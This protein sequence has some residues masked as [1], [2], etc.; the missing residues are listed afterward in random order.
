MTDDHE[1][2]AEALEQRISSLSAAILRINESLDLA[3]VLREVVECACSLTATTRGVIATTDEAGAVLEYVSAGFTDEEHYRMAAW[4]DGP[5]LF[6]HMRDLPAPL[7][8]TNLAEWVCEL[9][10]ATDILPSEALVGMPLRHRGRHVGNFFVGMKDNGAE[11]TS[12]DEEILALFASQAATAIANAR[13]HQSEQRAR[14]DLEALIDTSPVGVVVF[15]VGTGKAPTINREAQRIVESLRTP[16][17]PVE[18]LLEEATCRLADGREIPFDQFPLAGVLS[19]AATTRAEEIVLS[20]PGGRRVSALINATPIRSKEGAVE[21]MVVTMQDLAPIEELERQRAAFLDMVSHELRAPLAAITGSAVTL[22]STAAT[23]DRSEMRAFFRIIT[24]QAEHMRSLVSDLLD[25]GRI[26]SGAL[27]VLP[28][29]SDVATLVD[30]ARNTFVSGGARHAVAIDLAPHLPRVMAD[31]R[32]IVQV[33]INLLANAARQAPDTAP[34]RIRAVRDATHVA[35]SVRDEGRG[36][37]PERLTQLFRKHVHADGGNGGSGISGGLGLAICKGLVEAHGGRIRAE[38]DG[39]GTG[40]CFTFTVPVAAEA[41]MAAA[42]GEGQR[43]SADQE[44]AARV[45]VVDDDPQA[46]RFVRE[47]LTEAGFTVLVTG[48]H[49]ELS[50]LVE[51]EH[52]DLILLDLVLAD[53]DGIELMQHSPELAGLPVIFISA[54]GRDATIARALDGGAADYIVKPFSPTELVARIRAALRG[55]AEPEPFVL[56]DLAIQYA[57]RRVL[58]AGKPVDLTATEFELLRA[59]SLAA[60]RV[61]TYDVLLHRVWRGAGDAALVRAFV[62]QLRRKLGDNP[63]EPVWIFNQRGVGYRMPRPEVCTGPPRHAAR[64]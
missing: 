17:R 14:A 28:E 54:Y 53:T 31:R 42:D 64:G 5:R 37:A 2:R 23:L 7:R 20:V 8:L 55:R 9:G 51:T 13:I 40:A 45:L 3:T 60:G 36:I 29:P 19:S 32:R 39:P 52:P 12:A 62:K 49:R 6:A 61:M 58:V 30:R 38:S 59:L 63:R 46:L 35:V 56:G 15:N 1:R 21:T 4:P 44:L 43:R 34:I 10:F 47:A 33:L 27:S 50:R 48:D 18:H 11:F 16:G 22:E 26:D 57:A 25:A 41:D 24:E